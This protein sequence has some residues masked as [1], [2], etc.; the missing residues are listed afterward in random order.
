MTGFRRADEGTKKAYLDHRWDKKVRAS[1]GSRHDAAASRH[2]HAIDGYIV[3]Y[4][5]AGVRTGGKECLDG[6]GA[7]GIPTA[8]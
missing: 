2:T 7:A 1:L 4:E 8:A 6:A 5:A 3:R